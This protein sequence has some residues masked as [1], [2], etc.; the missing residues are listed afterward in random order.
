[1]FD[2]PVGSVAI[3][4]ITVTPSTKLCDVHVFF[5]QFCLTQRNRVMIYWLYIIIQLLNVS[6]GSQITEHTG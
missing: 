5:F 4:D 1:M 6:F 2:A 3:T